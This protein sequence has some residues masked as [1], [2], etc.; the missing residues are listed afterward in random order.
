VARSDGWTACPR[1][2]RTHGASGH[3]GPSL[4]GWRTRCSV[5]SAIQTPAARSCR[6]CSPAES[7]RATISCSCWIRLWSVGWPPGRRGPSGPILPRRSGSSHGQWL[8]GH[9]RLHCRSARAATDIFP[10][11]YTPLVELKLP[12]EARCL[13]LKL[14]PCPFLP[15]AATSN[16]G[17][18]RSI[19]ARLPKRR[20]SGQSWR[21]LPPRGQVIGG[22]PRGH[23][24]GRWSRPH[25]SWA[26]PPAHRTG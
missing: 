26:R 10:T 1:R 19:P 13:I 24:G 25:R 6:S 20:D 17:P 2:W 22:L 16:L 7:R 11:L 21:R 4:A 3:H 18:D 5:R 15:E 14:P 12:S 9:S 23:G 8:T